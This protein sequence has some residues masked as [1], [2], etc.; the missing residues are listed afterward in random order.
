MLKCPRDEKWKNNF[1]YF[2]FRAQYPDNEWF[3]LTG[4]I[5]DLGKVMIGM[6]KH[7]FCNLIMT[8]TVS[9]EIIRLKS[10]LSNNFERF[11]KWD[12]V[13]RSNSIPSTYNLT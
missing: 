12:M 4:L 1:Q 7:I 9:I 8:T 5:H 6:T 10:F 13:D 11:S 3:Q 2:N